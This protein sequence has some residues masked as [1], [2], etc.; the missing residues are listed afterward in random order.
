MKRPQSGPFL[1]IFTTANR[2]QHNAADDK[3]ED[4]AERN[5][6]HARDEERV[7]KHVLTNTG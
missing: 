2:L 5:R 4:H 1:T 6:H 7:V 3:A